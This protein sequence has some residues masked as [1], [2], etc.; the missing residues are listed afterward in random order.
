MDI[1][2][3]K[4]WPIG[5]EAAWFGMERAAA[6]TVTVVNHAGA[7]TRGADVASVAVSLSRLQERF[8]GID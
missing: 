8:L 3:Y 6:W 1:Y 4:I 7:A 2:G 5:F